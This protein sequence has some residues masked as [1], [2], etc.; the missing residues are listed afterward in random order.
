MP[1]LITIFQLTLVVNSSGMGFVLDTIGVLLYLAHQKYHLY[2]Q[3]IVSVHTIDFLPESP[4]SISL[5]LSLAS[6]GF[7]TLC[8]NNGSASEY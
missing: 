1:K 8:K 7:L 5:R 6:M 4:A 3:W 2:V